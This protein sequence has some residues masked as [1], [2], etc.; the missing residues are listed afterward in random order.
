MHAGDAV[1]SV[2]KQQ[3]KLTANYNYALAA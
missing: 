1:H 3:Q 2:I